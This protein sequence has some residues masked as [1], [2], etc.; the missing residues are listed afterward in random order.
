MRTKINKVR[1][2]EKPSATTIN[3]IVERLN[4]Q[5]IQSGKGYRV[6]KNPNGTI[7]EI[8]DEPKKR[9]S[10]V[11]DLL[12]LG[13]DHISIFTGWVGPYSVEN[14]SLE[15]TTAGTIYLKFACD[16]FGYPNDSEDIEILNA[17]ETPENEAGYRYITLYDVTGSTGAFQFERHIFSSIT[18]RNC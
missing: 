14:E 9:H 18:R 3:N 15:I 11:F 16:D 5:E 13:D 6:R 1:K 7:L 12:Y 4:S 17:I 10:H 2:G 8:M